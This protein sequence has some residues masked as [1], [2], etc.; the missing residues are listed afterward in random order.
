[1][2][3][4]LYSDADGRLSESKIKAFTEA[5]AKFSIDGFKHGL[6]PPNEAFFHRNPWLQSS[7]R[8]NI[9]GK[10][11]NAE[12]ELPLQVSLRISINLT[13]VVPKFSDTLTLSQPKGAEPA[14][15]LRGRG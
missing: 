11:G 10:D 4:D 9:P 13:V 6:R 1:M 14:H 8:R 12:A 7:C 5:C 15:H 2:A 3:M